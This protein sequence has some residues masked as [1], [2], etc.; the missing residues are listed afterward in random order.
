M[1]TEELSSP[2]PGLRP[3]GEADRPW[4]FGRLSQVR[5]L[6][7]RLEVSHVVTVIGGSG[8]GKS[9][10]VRAGLLPYLKAGGL[11]KAGRH[12]HTVVFTPG[13]QLD[14][15]AGLSPFHN[16]ARAFLAVVGEHAPSPA[17]IDA[18][19]NTADQRH[20]LQKIV[21]AA[22]DLD[23][24]ANPGPPMGGEANFLFVIDQFEELFSKN[25][26]KSRQAES[27]VARVVE[28]A[29]AEHHARIFLV[30]TMRSEHLPECAGFPDFP[31]VINETSYLVRRMK[32]SELQEAIE[33]PVQMFCRQ[34]MNERDLDSVTE[35]AIVDDVVKAL[36]DEI[37]HLKHD[38][39]HLPLFQHSLHWLW[40]TAVTTSPG[41]EPELPAEINRVHL[42]K[43]LGITAPSRVPDAATIEESLSRSLQETRGKYLQRCLNYQADAAFCRLDDDH[44]VKA[45]RL[46]RAL[47]RR[48]EFQTYKRTPLPISKLGQIGLSRAEYEL[49]RDTINAS[50]GYL[51]DREGEIDIPHEALIRNWTRFKQWVDD[52][53]S[54]A[55]VLQRIVDLYANW[56]RRAGHK[57]Q[58]DYLVPEKTVESALANDLWQSNPFMS[59]R[60]YDWEINPLGLIPGSWSAAHEQLTK[61]LQAS[62][63]YYKEKRVVAANAARKKA[64]LRIL[65]L[66]SGMAVVVGAF[67]F[68]A[69]QSMLESEARAFQSYAIGAT[70]V[71]AISGSVEPERRTALLSSDLVGAHFL[72]APSQW[73]VQPFELMFDSERKDR[74]ALAPLQQLFETER[75]ERFLNAKKLSEVMLTD[76]LRR[77]L[78]VPIPQKPQFVSAPVRR[79]SRA[80]FVDVADKTPQAV[81]SPRRAGNLNLSY[82]AAVAQQPTTALCQSG[83]D[84]VLK[85][86]N[87]DSVMLGSPLDISTYATFP[88]G[89]KIGVDPKCEVMVAAVPITRTG[90]EYQ[91]S[92]HA[93]AWRRTVA[94]A[95]IPAYVRQ[96]GE[97]PGSI[98][99]VKGIRVWS[100]DSGTDFTT[101]IETD[102]GGPDTRS[103]AVLPFEPV[104]DRN[105]AAA[106]GPSLDRADA[107]SK[108]DQFSKL[109]PDP[110]TRVDWYRFEG[111]PTKGDLYSEVCI[112][113][114]S[115]N[116]HH[117]A[118]FLG[119][120]IRLYKLPADPLQR[121]HQRQTIP[122]AK[123][124]FTGPAI[125]SMQLDPAG[126]WLTFEAGGVSYRSPALLASLQQVACAVMRKVDDTTLSKVKADDVW[127]PEY[128]LLN[129]ASEDLRRFHKDMFAGKT[130]VCR[131]LVPVSALPQQD[132]ERK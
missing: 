44:A 33:R 30:I 26:L 114:L 18:I 75:K 8:C 119:A 129:S 103:F 23:S 62:A 17:R 72:T 117:P 36:L 120:Q 79:S 45:E 87:T 102:G 110:A 97:F 77:T 66:G 131:N 101:E 90:S 99:N 81:A 86:T 105:A 52:E 20:G 88:Q 65:L 92:V 121:A 113:I 85:V 107:Q 15:A 1:N 128:L 83:N 12:W 53:A 43:A 118:G 28:C 6:G 67:A 127:P 21:A 60:Y 71:G 39:D 108:C 64:R 69:L 106:A 112:Q 68:L 126:G 25:V 76:T 7:T 124:N 132:A 130:D 34:V 59:E 56:K 10:L 123:I 82:P 16:L 41:D 37:E 48:D 2:Y 35:P 42:S 91:I 125:E 4:F 100:D 9:S 22:R 111:S 46:F 27:L 89:S 116:Y 5:E 14:E 47:A 29:G 78:Q 115:G 38:P 51:W 58:A 73:W 95:W 54:R 57:D 50:H 63:D 3:F 11:P 32:G 13:Q 84:V 61:Y 31:E 70:T 94:A 19:V 49:I 24:A 55:E 80:N 98:K 104:L 74:W 109:R 93:I 40:R 122:V 96:H